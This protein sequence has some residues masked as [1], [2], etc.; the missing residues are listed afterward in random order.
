MGKKF[1][2]YGNYKRPTEKDL[3]IDRISDIEKVFKE[4]VHGLKSG[5]FDK[6]QYEIEKRE[7]EEELRI[8][9]RRLEKLSR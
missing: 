7:W 5:L 8:A 2:R 3:L 6:E 9:K 4:L 1:R